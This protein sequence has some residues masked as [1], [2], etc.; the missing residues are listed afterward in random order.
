MEV[1]GYTESLT[2]PKLLFRKSFNESIQC[3]DC[4]KLL[5]PDKMDIVVGTFSGKFLVLTQQNLPD[6]NQTIVKITKSDPQSEKKIK[7]LQGEVEKLQEKVIRQKTK[8]QAISQQMVS[9]ASQFKEPLFLLDGYFINTETGPS[10]D[11]SYT[12]SDP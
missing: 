5:Q 10:T 9:L 3:L 1:Y 6:S 2:T 12:N 11:I 4:G 8:Y 7:A